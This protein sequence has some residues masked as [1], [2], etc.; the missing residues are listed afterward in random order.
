VYT[1][2]RSVA[3][4]ERAKR[5]GVDLLALEDER[6]PHALRFIF[7]PPPVLYVKGRIERADLE[8]IAIV[9]SRDASAYG[10]STAERLGRELAAEGVTVV[11]G[12]AIGI[13]AAAHRGALAAG[14]RTIAVLG[15]GIDQIYPHRHRR[16]AAQIAE[17]G[18][19]VSEQPFGAPPRAHHFPLRNRIVSGLS[20][21]VVVVEAGEKSG[22]LIT[23]RLA[24]EQGRSV[25]A[26]PGEAGLDRT[27]GVHRLIRRGATLVESASDI[28][29]DMLPWRASRALAASVLG[30]EGRL[31]ID[32]RR[33]LAAFETT[34]E[35][36]D[37]LIER[38]GFNAARTLEILLELELA[39]RVRRHA[40]MVFA[41]LAG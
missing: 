26:V 9:G 2:N 8:A 41:K 28:L 1:G 10:L 40:G 14:G 22:S 13:D 32:H 30:A 18:A 5:L 23:A 19:V 12:L 29:D 17:S 33:V 38:S 4:I 27:R 15:S 11:S 36:I 3:E 35:H 31:S 34:T 39:G 7:D 6:Y 20:L 24:L 25:L 37:R 16:L 21:A